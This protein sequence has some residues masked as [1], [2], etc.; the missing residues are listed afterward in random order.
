MIEEV[1]L[2]T[3]K[4]IVKE[5]FKNE[6]PND[7]IPTVYTKVLVYKEEKIKGIL[8]Y[9]LIYD[10]I[11]IDY[12]LVLPEYRMHG[13]AK[14]LVNELILKNDV[15]MTLEVREDNIPAIHLYE[16][17]GFTVSAIR[18]NYYGDTNAILMIRGM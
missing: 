2:E 8:C 15:S 16:K 1:K 6:I 11:E 9:E 5:Y 10:R 4:D 13:I 3:V 18:E 17:F 7:L 14:K 12:I